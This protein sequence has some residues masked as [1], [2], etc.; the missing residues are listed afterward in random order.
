MKVKDLVSVLS[1][2]TCVTLSEQAH[3][4]EGGRYLGG[5]GDFDRLVSEYGE[6]EVISIWPASKDIVEVAVK[7]NKKVCPICGR[8]Y[9]GYPAL[10]RV[11]NKTEICPDCGVI[12]ALEDYIKNIKRKR[13]DC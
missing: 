2:A 6:T 7:K 13:G 1:S 12:E 8:E 10:S 5:Y 4:D 3:L 9:T 11:D